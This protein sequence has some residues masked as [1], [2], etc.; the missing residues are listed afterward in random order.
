MT[1][2]P[3]IECLQLTKK[4][5]SFTAVDS[6]DLVV[7]KGQIYGFLGPNGAGKT[8]TI[9]MITGLIHPTAGT[10]RI[11][12]FDIQKDFYNASGKIGVM[13][14]LPG[15]Y[16]Y[17]SGYQNL[18][19]LAEY[20]GLTDNRKRINEVLEIVGLMERA[21]D[22][23]FT[24]SRGMLQR[25]GIAQALLSDPEI[26]ILDEPTNGLDPMGMFEI[27]SLIMQLS[28]HNNKTVFLSS[29]LLK[30]MESIC[31]RVVIINRGRIIGKGQM[32]DLIKD[33]PNGLEDYFFQLTKKGGK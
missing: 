15:F 24:Y 23:V 25:L 31:S 29:H 27:K 17:L 19:I 30:E 8:T 10:V 3:A 2:Q 9:R 32:K 14:E 12:G 11:C 5:G 1:H 13:L 6:L 21:K 7:E 33:H 20:S 4:Y 16:P 22:T 18:K 28:M 26:L